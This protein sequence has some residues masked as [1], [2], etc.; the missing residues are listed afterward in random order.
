MWSDDEDH[1]VVSTIIKDS[2][3]TNGGYDKTDLS[4]V[5]MNDSACVTLF[6]QEPTSN[7][8]S[9]HNAS[10]FNDAE[11]EQV[12]ESKVEKFDID[13]DGYFD[14][15]GWSLDDC[16]SVTLYTECGDESGVDKTVP[17]DNYADDAVYIAHNPVDTFAC[18]RVRG[19]K[20]KIN[21]ISAG[22]NFV[23][24]SPSGTTD[25]SSYARHNV[26]TKLA[27][28]SPATRDYVRAPRR[29]VPSYRPS[30]QTP[31][32]SHARGDHAQVFC[33]ES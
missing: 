13:D 28:N 15:H 27:K 4:R 30:A 19:R 10:N 6:K 14:N 18:A 17:D 8:A 9:E 1:G 3:S 12:T 23:K 21:K 24:Q 20:L 7:F 32:R 5:N 26:V 11:F 2:E 16:S 25:I 31:S 22:G 29:K 33:C